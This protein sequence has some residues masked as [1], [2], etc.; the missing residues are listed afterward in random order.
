MISEN[1]DRIFV[2]LALALGF[3]L[4]ELILFEGFGIA[5]PAYMALFYAAVFWYLK[6]KP[7]GIRPKGLL[8]LAPI[9]LL[10]VCF[11]LYDNMVLSMLDFMLLFAL[12]VLQLAT[13]TGN[14]LYKTFSLGLAIDLFHAG[15][16]L[17]LANIPAPFRAF[18]RNAP[19][20]GKSSRVGP[21][22]IGLAVSVPILAVVLGLLASADFV[23]EKSLN[24]VFSFLNQ[25]IMEYVFKVVFGAV[26]AIPLFGLLYALRNNRKI[27]GLKFKINFDRVK[28]VD[29]GIASTVLILMNVVYLAFIAVQF[30]YLFNAFS[31]MLPAVFTYAE[32]A[33]RGFFELMAVVLINLCVL[34]LSM[35]F[36]RRSGNGTA[37][38]KTMEA[39]QVLLT[40]LLAAS[41]M[42]KMVM[43]MDAYGLTLMRVYVAWFMILC[44]VFFVAI[45][46]KLFAKR[47]AL[48]RFC[49]GAFIAL[50]LILNYAGVD[51]RIAQY[52][53]ES[54]KSGELK[55][56]DVDTLYSLSDSMVPYAAE[57]LGDSSKAVAAKAEEL[58]ADRA[59]ILKDNRWQVF[60][61]A[62]QNAKKI[63]T[64]KGITYKPRPDDPGM[65]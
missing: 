32:Y 31:S 65:D 40:L 3:L 8:L 58:L 1:K 28:V 33:R 13:M 44:A 38:L 27:N 23:F 24:S 63:L 37:L 11:A 48:V 21:V 51:A 17:P 57:L 50:F 19:A 6:G 60:S 16:V 25:H 52:N 9:A 62:N 7:E 43:Y 54:Y 36:S 15:V 20:G 47:F 61:A 29:G 34:S 2:F 46:I 42:A 14:R 64:E 22:F 56:V 35:L 5:V 30:G 18:K 59:S 39:S 53:I 41:A 12:T 55:T 45:F 26:I 4:C 49:F 10:S